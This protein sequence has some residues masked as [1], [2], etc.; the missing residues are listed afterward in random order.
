VSPSLW[1]SLIDATVIVAG[2][3]RSVK[4]ILRTEIIDKVSAREVK[5]LG[6]R[7]SALLFGPPG[8]SK[9]TIVRALAQE[10]GWPYLEINPSHFLREGLNSIYQQADGIFRDLRDLSRAVVLFDEMDALVQ[11]RSQNLDVTREFLTT[12]MLPKLA[13]LHEGAQVIFFMATNHKAAF[14]PAI[15]RPGRFDILLFVGPPAWRDK[16]RSV[17]KLLS[18][19]EDPKALKTV[20]A[21]LQS[22]ATKSTGL[23][24]N[25]DLFTVGEFRSLLD[26][27]RSGARLSDAVAK[28]GAA[29]AFEAEVATWSERLITLRQ[30]KGDEA[31]PRAE[32]E[33]DRTAS[34]IQ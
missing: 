4:A 17:G 6:H 11:S 21:V 30:Q 24:R 16:I 31:S 10:I 15:T 33:T 12:S 20:S 13:E 27:F 8:T 18:G 2:Q 3:R 23:R 26:H 32:Y 1:D 19:T 25:L 28:S 7:R 9:T 34:I 5:R 22:W 29:K 14:D